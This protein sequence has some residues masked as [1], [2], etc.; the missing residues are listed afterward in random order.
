MEMGN[1][2]T[3]IRRIINRK[4]YKAPNKEGPIKDQNEMNSNSTQVEPIQRR[5][6]KHAD[7]AVQS[8]SENR[9]SAVTNC[10]PRQLPG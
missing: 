1:K 8:P 7:S 3:Q 10:Q 6:L 4:S 2:E 9:S 5:S